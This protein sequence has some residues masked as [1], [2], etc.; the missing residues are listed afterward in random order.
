MKLLPFSQYEFENRQRDVLKH[1]DEEKLAEL[2]G[3]YPTYISSMC[4]PNDER[5]SWTYHA[6]QFLSALHQISPSRED[7]LWRM[8]CTSRTLFKQEIGNTLSVD[9]EMEKTSKEFFELLQ[10][11]LSNQPYQAQLKELVDF[12]EQ[13][14]SHKKAL[15]EK[16][17]DERENG[18]VQ[19][20]NGFSQ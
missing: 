9:V 16:V 4:N 14:K 19:R 6:L 7:E 2:I 11:K 5:V 1:G 3:K 18:G 12:E 20:F 13:I 8:I 17:N 10:A 15:M